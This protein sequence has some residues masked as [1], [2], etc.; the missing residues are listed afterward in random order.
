MTK[1]LQQQFDWYSAEIE[2]AR[3]DLAKK[4]AAFLDADARVTAL[5]RDRSI[6]FRELLDAVSTTGEPNAK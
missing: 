6:V 5:E 1:D 3:P 4:R 2:K